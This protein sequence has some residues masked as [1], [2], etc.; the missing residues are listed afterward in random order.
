MPFIHLLACAGGSIL[1]VKGIILVIEAIEAR[2]EF[3]CRDVV[4]TVECVN[5]FTEGDLVLVRHGYCIFVLVVVVV[6]FANL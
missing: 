5:V 3:F 4:G 6:A 1:G 2:L